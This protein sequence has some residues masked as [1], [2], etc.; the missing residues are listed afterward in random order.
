MTNS[1]AFDELLFPSNPFPG[2]EHDAINGVKY[3]WDVNKLSWVI[4]PSAAASTDYVNQAVQNKVDRGGDFLYGSLSFKD[5]NNVTASDNLIISN[6]GTVTFNKDRTIDCAAGSKLK[7]SYNNVTVFD[8]DGYGITSHTPFRTGPTVNV[9]M[10]PAFTGGHFSI[11]GE[12]KSNTSYGIDLFNSNTCKFVIKSPVGEVF[13]VAGGSDG[14]IIMA[15]G[16]SGNAFRVQNSGA[17]NIF[18]VDTSNNMIISSSYYNN[19][20]KER[21]TSG[22]VNFT[23]ETLL[24]TLGYVDYSIEDRIGSFGPGKRVCAT[25][26]NDADVGG[27]YLSGTTLYIKVS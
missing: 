16:T 1:Y 8:Y 12:T 2:Q 9:G 14:V 25:N 19:K 23:E 6:T 10:V 20:M 18:S 22:G 13:K 3:V 11:I 15:P 21:S 17:S 27:F 26:E 5:V 4:D 7:F 24:A